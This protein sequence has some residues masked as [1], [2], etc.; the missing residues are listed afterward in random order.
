MDVS[1][2][3]PKIIGKLDDSPKNIEKSLGIDR[4]KFLKF[5]GELPSEQIFYLNILLGA[6]DF[7]HCH[8]NKKKKLNKKLN[9]IGNF[10]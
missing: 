5:L 1:A 8:R 3:F 2:L 4:R 10:T 9:F 7:L 6:P